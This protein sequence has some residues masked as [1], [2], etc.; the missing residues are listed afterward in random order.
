MEGNVMRARAYGLVAASPL[1]RF[2]PLAST[3]ARIGISKPAES[4]E[5]YADRMDAYFG[6]PS[7]LAAARAQKHSAPYKRKKR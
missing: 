2:R 7:S 1:A 6:S 3:P 5:Q 4:F